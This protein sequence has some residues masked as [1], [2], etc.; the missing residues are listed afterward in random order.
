M[1]KIYPIEL[2]NAHGL[3]DNLLLCDEYEFT[4][5]KDLF[6][7]VE[8]EKDKNKLFALL[9]FLKTDLVRVYMYLCDNEP[10]ESFGCCS[11][12]L[13]CSDNKRCVKQ[14]PKFA[15]GCTYRRNLL[16]GKIFYSLLNIFLRFVD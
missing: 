13:E 12:Y 5:T 1:K 16:K 10:V 3:F 6:I 4:K 14:D 2:S 8:S 15:K 11:Q 7:R 9:M